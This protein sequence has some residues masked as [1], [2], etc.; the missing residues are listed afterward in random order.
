MATIKP[1]SVLNENGSFAINGDTYRQRRV[2]AASTVEVITPPDGA[3][4]VFFAATADFHVAYGSSAVPISSDVA[5]GSAPEL[6]PT[7]RQIQGIS[8]IGVVSPATCI[9]TASFYS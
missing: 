5:D 1:L 3:N 8:K 6:N 4:Y 9:V 2:L 7:V